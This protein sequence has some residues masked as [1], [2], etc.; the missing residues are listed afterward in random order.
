MGAIGTRLSCALCKQEGGRKSK[1]GQ[2][3]AQECGR[4]THRSRNTFTVVPAK[5]GTHNH[6][7]SLFRDAGTTSAIHNS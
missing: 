7:C 6:R 3:M 5:A 4:M 2:I 1:L